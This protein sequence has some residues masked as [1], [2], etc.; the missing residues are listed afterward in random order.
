MKLK[1]KQ[2]TSLTRNL[3]VAVPLS[4]CE[5]LVT[6]AL[7]RRDRVELGPQQLF[8]LVGVGL[9]NFQNDIE[10]LSPLFAG[11]GTLLVGNNPLVEIGELKP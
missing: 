7:T 5:E 1:T 10:E 6:V 3:T 11:D 8:R 2:F 9:S 4:S